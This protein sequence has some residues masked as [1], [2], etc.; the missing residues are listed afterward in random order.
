MAM[1]YAAAGAGAAS[2][3]LGRHIQDGRWDEAK[4]MLR[5]QLLSASM[6]ARCADEQGMLPLHRALEQAAP[7]SIVC[8]LLDT[9][10]GAAKHRTLHGRLALHVAAYSHAAPS[11]V[12]A[13]LAGGSR[14]RPCVRYRSNSPNQVSNSRSRY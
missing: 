11:I 3:R 12:R 1:N 5:G 4:A 6:C 2:A 14:P 10:P 8:S 7:V 9:Y 13:L